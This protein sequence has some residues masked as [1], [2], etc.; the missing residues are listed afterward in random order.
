VN[1]STLLI[2][3]VA[4]ALVAYYM[5]R[6]RAVSAA[7][8]V[9]STRQVHSLPGYHGGYVALWC[10]LPALAV[11]VLWQVFE[12]T[13]LR[14][15]VIAALPENLRS[16]PPAELGLVYN[17]IRNLVAGSISSSEPTG[18]GEPGTSGRPRSL[19][20]CLATIFSR[21]S[22]SPANI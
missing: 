5:G 1:S 21:K 10:A 7:L 12:P 17:D 16:L 3:V 4:L 14:N 19:A 13:W 2:V 8:A 18:P 6:Q 20:V 22:A 11:L 15:N 9:S